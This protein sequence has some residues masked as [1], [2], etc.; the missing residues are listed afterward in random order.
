M[1][2]CTSATVTVTLGC[3]S[4][5]ARALAQTRLPV[6]GPGLLLLA[7]LAVLALSRRKGKRQRWSTLAA[8]M[9]LAVALMGIGTTLAGDDSAPVALA[10]PPASAVSESHGDAPLNTMLASRPMWAY[11]SGLVK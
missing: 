9:L 3:A 2:G 7:P 6:N 11:S 4:N 1:P 5:G 10:A 8:A